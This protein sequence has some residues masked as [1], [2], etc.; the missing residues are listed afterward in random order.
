[1][2][3]IPSVGFVWASWWKGPAYFWLGPPA[4]I[5]LNPVWWSTHGVEERRGLLLHEIGHCLG[6]FVYGWGESFAARCHR[7]WAEAR[8]ERVGKRWWVDDAAVER[9]IE[10]G[11]CVGWEFAA[12]WGVT[13]GWAAERLAMYRARWPDRDGVADHGGGTAGAASG[14]AGVSDGGAVDGGPAAHG[15]RG[16]AHGGGGPHVVGG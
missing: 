6:P 9:A 16:G 8:A 10:A 11:C 4:E 5:G 7:H 13:N 12:R 1:M 3:A 15:F 14:W 2:R